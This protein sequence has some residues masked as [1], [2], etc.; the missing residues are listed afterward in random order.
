MNFKLFIQILQNSFGSS[1]F[2]KQT[3]E[4]QCDLKQQPLKQTLKHLVKLAK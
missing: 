3:E 2:L 4:L 1:F